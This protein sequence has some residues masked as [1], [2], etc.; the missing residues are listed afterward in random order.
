MSTQTLNPDR[1]I[2]GM[3]GSADV[4]RDD[5]AAALTQL[6]HV[7]KHEAEHLVAIAGEDERA[8]ALKQKCEFLTALMRRVDDFLQDDEGGYYQMR[9]YLARHERS[10][11]VLEIWFHVK[12][13]TRPR[14]G[15]WFRHLV[16]GI[17]SDRV[18]AD[19]G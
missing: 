10:P 6:E 19:F 13:P 18:Y 11:A 2:F 12:M 3:E 9:A 14:G 5:L 4:Y 15:T 16:V 17:D 7:D 8:Y 1:V